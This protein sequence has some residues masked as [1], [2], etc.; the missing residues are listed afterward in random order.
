MSRL[1]AVVAMVGVYLLTMGVIVHGT[2]ADAASLDF[3]YKDKFTSSGYNGNNGTDDFSQPWWES[4]D[5][6]GPNQ[7]FVSVE[8]GGDCP[9]E[10]C[11]QIS[12]DPAVFWGTGLM[13]EADTE[14]AAVVKIKFKYALDVHEQTGGYFN[15][16]VFDGTL[17]HVVDSIFLAD[18]LDDD[19]GEVHTKVYNVTSYA[20]RDFMVG[21]FAHGDWH[22]ELSLDNI[23]VFGSWDAPST[24]TTTTTTIT[25][26]PTTT[27]TLLPPT[28]S[29]TT[30]TVAPTTT[31]TTTAAPPTTT[32]APPT[33][34]KAPPTTTK[35]PAPTTTSVPT[36]TQV[37]AAPPV[38][39]PPTT[40]TPTK[41]P[42]TEDERYTQKGAL[43]ALVLEDELM[44]LPANELEMA[45]PGPVTQIMA[46]ITTTAV[47][48]RSHLLSAMALGLLIAIA[49]IWGLG[50][51]E[52]VS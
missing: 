27:T 12:G 41:L 25:L 39:V 46:S 33:T 1:K 37:I 2:P 18:A 17:W 11:V 35:A 43:V 32:T 10:R 28:T 9:N 14:G 49:A 26:P 38:S 8:S 31:T 16:G 22:A 36:T 51:R 52:T 4:L 24:T 42:Y 5:W 7:G 30:T 21:F 13:R 40:A 50:K 47:T 15:V 19:G 20:H 6:G 48:V 3:E 23:E 34:T 44:E 45:S 29:T